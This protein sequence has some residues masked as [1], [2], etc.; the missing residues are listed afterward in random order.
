MTAHWIAFAVFAAMILTLAYRNAALRDEL[1]KARAGWE[2]AEDKRLDAAYTALAE[3]EAARERAHAETRLR[4][5]AEERA[6]DLEATAANLA[7]D[8][9]RLHAEVTALIAEK[10]PA[11]PAWTDGAETMRG[12][13][14][15]LLD[16]WKADEDG[17]A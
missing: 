16:G 7:D 14:V 6:D 5:E 3:A 17:A 11:D 13:V 12:A 4:I 2:N 8:Y 1:R 9:E 10:I 15:R